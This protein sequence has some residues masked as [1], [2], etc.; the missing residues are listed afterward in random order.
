MI[1]KSKHIFF[2][3]NI[4]ESV[5]SRYFTFLQ[6]SPVRYIGYESIGNHNL[7]ISDSGDPSFICNYH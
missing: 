5:L 3:E 1:I 7:L 2:N 4:P 6:E